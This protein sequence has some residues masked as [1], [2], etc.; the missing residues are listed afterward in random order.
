MKRIMRELGF[1]V[2]KKR[3]EEEKRLVCHGLMNFT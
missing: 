3:E 2:S 1:R